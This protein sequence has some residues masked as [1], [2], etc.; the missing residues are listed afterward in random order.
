MRQRS[1]C[2]TRHG[3]EPGRGRHGLGMGCVLVLR[4]AQCVGG[5]GLSCR[6]PQHGDGDDDGDDDDE[7]LNFIIYCRSAGGRLA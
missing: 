1:C 6:P 2:A 7:S 4:L 3:H 5:W